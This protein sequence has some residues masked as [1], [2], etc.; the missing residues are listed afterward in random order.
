MQDREELR[1]QMK[2]KK[3]ARKRQLQKLKMTCKKTLLKSTKKNNKYR[4][5][6]GLIEKGGGIK[7]EQLMIFLK[8][9]TVKMNVCV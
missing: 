5:R 2:S 4:D 7:I 6:K 8:I 9:P 1:R 3:K